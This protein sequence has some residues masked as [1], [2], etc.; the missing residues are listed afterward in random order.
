MAQ[1]TPLSI[2]AARDDTSKLTT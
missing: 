1:D 2:P